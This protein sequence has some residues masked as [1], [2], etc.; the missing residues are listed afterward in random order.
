MRVRQQTPQGHFQFALLSPQKF[1]TPMITLERDH[2]SCKPVCITDS[3][4]G[5]WWRAR[6]SLL[7]PVSSNSP[8]KA[9]PAPLGGLSFPK[10]LPF[11]WQKQRALHGWS[12]LTGGAAMLLQTHQHDPAGRSEAAAAGKGSLVQTEIPSA[13]ANGRGNGFFV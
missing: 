13:A 12:I 3:I 9:K 5:V 8:K 11:C 2:P 7:C 1:V 4:S 10:K 6:G